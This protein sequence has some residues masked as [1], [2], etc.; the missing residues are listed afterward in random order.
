MQDVLARIIEEKRE[1]VAALRRSTT[2]V[3][4][5]AAARAASPVRGFTRA[6]KAA[7]VSGYGLIA[8]LKK[9]SPSKGLFARISTRRPGEGL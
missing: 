5:M 7:S 3:D 4:L 2:R 6:L 9:A 1:E 8:E